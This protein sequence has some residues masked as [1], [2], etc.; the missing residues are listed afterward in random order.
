[1]CLI[2]AV[3]PFFGIDVR[4][5]V[6]YLQPAG[7]LLEFTVGWIKV[8]VNIYLDL[9]K[10]NL[11]WSSLSR[12][13]RQQRIP[14]IDRKLNLPFSYEGMITFHHW[15][16]SWKC[17]WFFQPV[18]RLWWVSTKQV[19]AVVPRIIVAVTFGE[20]KYWPA[21]CAKKISSS[22]SRLLCV[23]LDKFLQML[24]HESGDRGHF[25]VFE[26]KACLL[27]KQSVLFNRAEDQGSS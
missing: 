15:S 7:F 2:R 24:W 16:L 23:P 22:G 27:L 10:R 9:K 4:I 8:R 18:V 20:E 1:M 3:W 21:G 25:S 17:L 13:V 11:W 26:V 5:R 14:D 19:V 6:L 12:E